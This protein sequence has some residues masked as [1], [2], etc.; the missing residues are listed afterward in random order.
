MLHEALGLWDVKRCEVNEQFS[1]SE[2]VGNTD[3]ENPIHIFIVEI[4]RDAS[5]MHRASK[6]N[7]MLFVE[8]ILRVRSQVRS[9]EALPIREFSPRLS[10]PGQPYYVGLKS[11]PKSSLCFPSS[12]DPADA[13][14]LRK[15][16]G[17]Q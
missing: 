7:K 12:R 14:S 3:C 9:T 2:S 13:L 8:S 1:W 6:T 4:P 11:I 5:L 16:N 15:K 17:A 10:F